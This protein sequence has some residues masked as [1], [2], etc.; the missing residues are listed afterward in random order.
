[1]SYTATAVNVMIAS[2]GDVSRERRL[3]SYDPEREFVHP[4]ASTYA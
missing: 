2:P 4:A 3:R 1:M